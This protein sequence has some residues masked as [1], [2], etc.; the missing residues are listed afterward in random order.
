MKDEKWEWSFFFAAL[1][2]ISFAVW[3]AI[4]ILNL[5][6]IIRFGHVLSWSYCIL[7]YCLYTALRYEF[8]KAVLREETKEQNKL[9]SQI[10]NIGK[11]D[12]QD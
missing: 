9:K 4:C 1:C 8:D 10:E 7:A 12:T 2:C 11:C 6:L 5:V 3:L